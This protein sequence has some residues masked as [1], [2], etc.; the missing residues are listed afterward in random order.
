[1]TGLWAIVRSCI[2]DAIVNPHF[3]NGN[4]EI[5]RSKELLGDEWRDICL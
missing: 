5:A 3:E 1:M 4:R 2:E